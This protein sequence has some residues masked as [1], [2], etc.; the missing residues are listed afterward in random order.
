[1][2][3]L[4]WT[5]KPR[6][7][8]GPLPTGLVHLAGPAGPTGLNIGE[9]RL[10]LTGA[11]IVLTLALRF[12]YARTRF[13]LATSAI[14][15]NR[16]AAS[17]LGWSAHAVELV[18]FSLAGALSALAAIFLAPTLGL[19]IVT[20]TLLVL[21]A[22]AA[23]L[24]GRFASFGLTV[25]GAMAIGA[26]QSVLSRYVHTTGVA[27][28][29]PFLVIVAVIVAGGRARPARGDMPSR[30]PLPGGGSAG[31]VLPG[32]LRAHAVQ[33]GGSGGGGREPAAAPTPI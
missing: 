8:S 31:G 30:L 21:P 24:L 7:V 19:T 13:G 20:L 2:D 29:V 18:N 11:A 12:L 26:M 28:S 16:R 4:E 9:D 14:A 27:D 25:I 15:E 6:L 3:L 33:A 23:A 1:M 5:G 32:G 10:M 22:L 17:T